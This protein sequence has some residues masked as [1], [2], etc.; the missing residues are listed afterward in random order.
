MI[1]NTVRL[2]GL[3]TFGNELNQ[4]E[5]SLSIADNVNIDEPNVITQRRG[6]ED[7]ADLIDDS[8][9]RIRQTL[10]YKDTLIRHYSDKLEF[11][12]NNLFTQ[13]NGSYTEPD[14]DI[15]IKSVE[16]N[17]NFYFTTQEGIKK[18][19]ATSP[20]EFSA[21]AGY[22]TNAGVPAALDTFGAIVY[23]P[24]GFLPPES[25]VAYKVLFGK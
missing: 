1:S 16:A 13:F 25:K 15:R 24:T 18:I 8:E 20:S 14:S 17:S 4:P 5:G 19:A 23:S 9:T 2:K 11:E 21:S 12:S 3:Y 7:F 6:F 10:V 22:I